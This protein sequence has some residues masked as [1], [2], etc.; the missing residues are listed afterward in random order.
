MN[1]IKLFGEVTKVENGNIKKFIIKIQKNKKEKY[2]YIPCITYL[3]TKITPGNKIGV[4]GELN[5]Y[6]KNKKKCVSVIV[7][8]VGGDYARWNIWEFNKKFT[9]RNRI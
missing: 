8:E 6:Y 9:E 2:I 7:N 4:K 5:I 3:N 1:E